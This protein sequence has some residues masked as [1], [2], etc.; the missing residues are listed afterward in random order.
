MLLGMD[1]S[2]SVLPFWVQ[3]NTMEE[4]RRSFAAAGDGHWFLWRW[5]RGFVVT[6][7]GK[8][9]LFLLSK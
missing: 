3:S 4:R 1:V 6:E 2:C 5:L 9:E 8:E 7:E